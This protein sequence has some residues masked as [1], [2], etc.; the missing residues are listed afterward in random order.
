MEGFTDVRCGYC[1]TFLG[2]PKKCPTCNLDGIPTR[3]AVG[4]EARE[5][6]IWKHNP[7]FAEAFNGI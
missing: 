6:F 2:T 3:K 7:K 1:G 4:R 5:E